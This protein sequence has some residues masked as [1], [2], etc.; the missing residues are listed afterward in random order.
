MAVREVLTYPDPVL[1]QVCTPAQP[2]DLER[3]V[4][5][6]L[7]TMASF[8]HCVGLAAPQIGETVRVAVVDLSGHP[9]AK[10][11]HG[12]MVL[13]NPRVVARS[14]GSK[15]SRE[16]C[17]SLP[18]LTANVRRPR[19][20]TVEFTGIVHPEGLPP[21]MLAV[22][23]LAGQGKSMSPR[24]EPGEYS[25]H[26]LELASFEARCVLHEIDHLDGILF[27]DRV[28]SITDDL[29]RRQTYS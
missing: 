1:K 25:T 24:F 16:G 21:T 26:R 29:F 5:D 9:K 27:L 12:L 2:E 3:V 19:K 8:D 4:T 28:A 7:D 22:K 14:E 18:D 15:V 23:D 6:L 20:A 10:D 11:P 17:L 13:I